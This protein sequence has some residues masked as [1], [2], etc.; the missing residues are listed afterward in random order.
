M[1]EV[2]TSPAVCDVLLKARK[3]ESI[4]GVILLFGERGSASI[5]WSK[6]A[7]T[8]YAAGKSTRSIFDASSGTHL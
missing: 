6:T 5:Q 4:L 2:Q 3:V 1:N 8:S 7:A